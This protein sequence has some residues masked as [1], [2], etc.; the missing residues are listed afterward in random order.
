[1]AIVTRPN[2]TTVE[3]GSDGTL[4]TTGGTRKT[5]SSGG[6]GNSAS[7]GGSSG[8]SGGASSGG[9]G[10]VSTRSRY[11]DTNDSLFG[12]IV[13]MADHDYVFP[14]EQPSY[15]NQYDDQTKKELAQ[16]LGREAFDFD[17]DTDEGY[18]AYLKEYARLGKGAMRDVLAQT[19]LNSGGLPNSYG[20][21]AAMQTRGD[22][23]AAAAAKLPEMLNQAYTRYLNEDALNRSDVQLVNQ[24]EQYDYD[25]YMNSLNQ[26]NVDRGFDY[27][28]FEGKF[29]RL[30]TAL[31]QGQQLSDTEYGRNVNQDETAWNRATYADETA[32]NRAT[33]ADQT[34]WERQMYLDSL[35]GAGGSGG[36]SSGGA[37]GVWADALDLETLKATYGALELVPPQTWKALGVTTE[38]DKKRII[39]YYNTKKSNTGTEDVIFS[40][41]YIKTLDEVQSALS[42]GFLPADVLAASIERK[43]ENGLL[44]EQEADMIIG[45]SG[46]GAALEKLGY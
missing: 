22:Y 11:D 14:V 36:S 20:V 28:V 45:I 3:I 15:Y 41:E 9:S 42:S 12:K 43:V 40:D 19:A 26:W 18:Q 38:A 44:T 34:A 8:A 17:P 23:A 46:V 21:S 24:Q 27:G 30:N 13:G 29:G 35:L 39:E 32:Y 1:M 25:K 6:S 5:G 2:G 37:G 7:S 4:K 16:V 31:D 10:G 33:Y